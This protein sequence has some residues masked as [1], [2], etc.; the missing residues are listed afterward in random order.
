MHPSKPRDRVDARAAVGLDSRSEKDARMA[1][2][3]QAR[4]STAAEFDGSAAAV[5][6]PGTGITAGG[7]AF[8]ALSSH[9]RMQAL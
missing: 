5:G 3:E 4:R 1:A 2:S 7:Q 8:A 6:E 9:P